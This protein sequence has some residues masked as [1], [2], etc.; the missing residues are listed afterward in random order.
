[1]HH[2]HNPI[3]CHKQPPI[4]LSAPTR[5]SSHRHLFT[6]IHSIFQT[7]TSRLNSLRIPFTSNCYSLLLFTAARIRTYHPPTAHT[8]FLLRCVIPPPFPLQLCN[9]PP[10]TLKFFPCEPE[11]NILF[12]GSL[13]PGLGMPSP[14]ASL[15]PDRPYGQV[16]SVGRHSTVDLT[17]ELPAL[18]PLPPPPPSPSCAHGAVVRC[19]LHWNMV[20]CRPSLA[21]RVSM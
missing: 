10:V 11:A 17:S 3:I 5:H 19:P 1:M 15:L 18:L 16:C 7:L 13:R 12:V 6:L 14:Y 9:G 20:V 21:Y 8:L 2:P 4:S